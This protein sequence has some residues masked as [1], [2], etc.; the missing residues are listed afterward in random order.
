[1]PE[2]KKIFDLFEGSGFAATPKDG[3]EMGER[4]DGRGPRGLKGEEILFTARVLSAVNAFCSMVSPRSYRKAL[5]VETALEQLKKDKGFD[6]EVVE[7]LCTIPVKDFQT[8]VRKCTGEGDSFQNAMALW[9]QMDPASPA[10]SD[11]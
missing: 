1:M 7:A 6:P 11:R 8:I 10:N 9:D 3:Y 2:P 5:S 4:V